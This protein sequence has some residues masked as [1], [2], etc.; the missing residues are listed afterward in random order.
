MVRIAALFTLAVRG[1]R[2]SESLPQRRQE[3]LD[4]LVTLTS[5]PECLCHG[6]NGYGSE[7]HERAAIN[8]VPMGTASPIF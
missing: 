4:A 8:R 6:A 7:N 3:G 2:R 5:V 1:V